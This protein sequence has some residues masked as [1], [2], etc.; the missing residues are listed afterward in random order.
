MWKNLTK[1]IE[2][3]L[4]SHYANKNSVR[5]GAVDR[6]D[7]KLWDHQ[8]VGPHEARVLIGYTAGM[9]VP[10]RSEVDQWVV[11][12]FNG[13]MRTVLETIRPVQDQPLVV[14]HV[15]KI[16]EVR[17]AVHSSSMIPVSASTFM[18]DDDQVWE[19]RKNAEGG[20]FLA[21]VSQEDLDEL[22]KSKERNSHTAAVPGR[23][24]LASAGKGELLIEEGDQ[25]AF[26]LHGMAMNGVV[27]AMLADNTLKV[28]ANNNSFVI[29]S[30][31]VFDVKKVSAKSKAM[32]DQEYIDFYSQAYGNK[33]Y[34][35]ELVRSKPEM[36]F[37]QKQK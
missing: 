22:L 35:T 15:I 1:S 21:R 36:T 17:P 34:A 16:P 5:Q 19:R 18:D 7:L 4:Q 25:V 26:T 12:A 2:Q 23:P 13:S 10:K 32:S 24:R 20:E 3:R 31:S 37:D 11:K 30:G 29:P 14:A 9:G 6:F 33:E 8:V 28:T 27:A